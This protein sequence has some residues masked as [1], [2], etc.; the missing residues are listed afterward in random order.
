MAVRRIYILLIGLIISALR[1]SAEETPADTVKFY[2]LD[3]AFVISTTKETNDLRL[4]PT[5]ISVISPQMAESYQIDGLKDISS[6]VPNLYIPDYGSKMT[7]SVYIRGIGTRSGAQSIGLYVDGVSY[8]DRSAYDFEFTDIRRIEVLRGPQG[9]LYGRNT[10]GGILNVYTL[11]P[12]TYQGTKFSVSAGSYWDVTAKIS[13]YHKFGE[14]VG[15][16]VS[17]YYDRNSGF[18]TNAYDGD[19]ADHEDSAGGRL[20][21]DW[22]V[23]DNL[24]LRYSINYNFTDQ[25]AFPY[26]LYDISSGS[27][28]PVNVND[29]CSYKRNVLNT[30]LYLSWSKEKFIL[31]STTAY[32]RLHDNMKMDQD[33]SASSIYTLQQRQSQYSWSEELAIKSNAASNYQWS[34][35]LYGFYNSLKTTAPVTFK[36]DGVSSILQAAFDEIVAGNPY[37]PT[38]TVVGDENN[39][40]NFPGTYD[41]PTHGLAI[42]HQST[43]NNLFTEGLSIT[44]GVRLDYE[45]AKMDYN[46]S[47]EDMT[48]GVAVGQTEMSIP[49]T[50]VMEGSL[51]RD[52]WQVLPKVS[53]RY[54]CSPRTYSYFS[55]AKGY[56]TGGYNIQMFAD[57]IQAQAKYE[58][59]SQFASSMAEEP[60]DVKDAASYKPEHSW[61]YE[62]GMYSELVKDRLNVEFTAFYMD[63][64]N[65]Q[66]TTFTEM[67]NGRMI[68][69]AGRSKS[70]GVELSAHWNVVDGLTAD[71][72]YGFTRATF[73]DYVFTDKDDD[74]NLVEVDCSGNFIPYTPRH[75]LSVALNYAKSLNKRWI[76]R[77]FASAQYAGAG[78]IYW[79]EENTASQPFYG[80]LNAR[81][82]VSKG[83][84]TLSIWSRNITDTSYHT[85]YF[86]SLGSSF[87][88]RGRPFQI[89]A[90]L[91]LSF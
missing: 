38:L 60:V 15:L 24:L 34:F 21:L 22:N 48:I 10:M 66:L 79:T 76:D 40:I 47:V 85:F 42:F 61:N 58:M 65:V 35:G 37:A 49:V 52:F 77:V 3:E 73:R 19:K 23:R 54:Q 17:G 51:S 88:Q 71:L 18:F 59:M 20:R 46:A 31:S 64:R 14:K 84:V 53:L 43:Y 57:L 55:V 9:T 39:S 26:Q 2:N 63:I 32:Q 33:Y 70:L 82:G 5:S 68:T 56:K 45:K 83:I 6:H 12:L 29:P 50:T 36:E 8:M 89:G 41:T 90:E 69:N 4:L 78:K 27:T 74:G 16:A 1:L 28:S 87:V 80:T 81:A 62:F 25:G 91:S 67:G 44:A 86:E 72:N 75:T 13:H 11:S 7:S 30:S